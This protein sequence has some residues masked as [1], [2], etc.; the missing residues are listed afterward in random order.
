MF[1]RAHWRCVLATMVVACCT[2]LVFATA[3]QKFLAYDAAG[4]SQGYVSC[5]VF[6]CDV[7]TSAST[8]LGTVARN[9]QVMLRGKRRGYVAGFG[10]NWRPADF[11]VRP[12]ADP[13][14]PNPGDDWVRALAAA[15]SGADPTPRDE[16]HRLELMALQA[17]A[18]VFEVQN[19][20]ISVTQ[21]LSEQKTLEPH[22]ATVP[23]LVSPENAATEIMVR[24]LWV[25]A[26][27]PVDAKSYE[28]FWSCEHGI[29]S[30]RVSRSELLRGLSS[31]GVVVSANDRQVEAVPVRAESRTPVATPGNLC[32]SGSPVLRSHLETMLR[33]WAGLP[34]RC[35]FGGNDLVLEIRPTGRWLPI[36][37]L[38]RGWKRK[39]PGTAFEAIAV[40]RDR[41]G[42]ELWSVR[43]GSWEGHGLDRRAV[44]QQI[45]KAFTKFFDSFPG[46]GS[47]RSG[48]GSR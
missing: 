4:N 20:T 44:A 27:R 7:F 9:G 11:W 36:V 24:G 2:P 3:V 25:M 37:D 1:H 13:V 38:S 28:V 23:V 10:E 14:T 45:A 32:L 21:L 39:H 47:T 34:I 15:L 40:L 43:K 18:T 22:N 17:L 48:A 6:T 8:H 31:L 46:R 42:S 5:T 12:A 19:E 35:E 33:D 29:E 26:F 41:S 16:Q 30:E